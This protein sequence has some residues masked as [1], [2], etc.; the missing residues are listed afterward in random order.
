MNL[1]QIKDEYFTALNELS[2]MDEMP[3]EAIK[4]TLEGIQGEF[5]DKAINVAAYIKNLEADKAAIEEAINNMKTRKDRVAAHAERLREY[6]K[7]A[8]QGMGMAAI[9][10]DEFDIKIKNNPEKLVIFDE[11][12][13]PG[14]YRYYRQEEVVDNAAIKAALKANVTVPGAKLEQ[15]KRMEI[16]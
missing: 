1:Y 4:D 6:L 15:A 9:K 11:E 10:H 3:E 5:K 14:I 16:K 13:V 2:L 12:Q 8:M 7:S